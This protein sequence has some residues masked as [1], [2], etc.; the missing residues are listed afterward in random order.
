MLTSIVLSIFVLPGIIFLLACL[1]GFH[2]ALADG[3]PS[4]A[5]PSLVSVERLERIDSADNLRLNRRI[6][7]FPKRETATVESKAKSR[8]GPKI[9]TIIVT[10]A[11]M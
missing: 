6:T 3:R 9:A 10:G 11:G 4:Q 8:R 1:R 5:L 7:L 2:R